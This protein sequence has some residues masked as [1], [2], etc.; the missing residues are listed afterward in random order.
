VGQEFFEGRTGR[1]SSDEERMT[2]DDGQMQ[3][4]EGESVE[5]ACE[6]RVSSPA[7][8]RARLRSQASS[9]EVAVSPLVEFS[10]TAFSAI[11]FTVDPFAAVPLFLTM[12]ANDT[13]GHRRRTALRAAV[14]VGVVLLLFAFAGGAIFRLFGISMGAF[15]MAGGLLL[16]LMALDMMRAH[17]SDTR[18]TDEEVAEGVDK[19]DVGIVPLGLPML[20]GPGAIATVTV[21]MNT[22]WNRPAHMTAVVACVLITTAIVYVVLRSAGPVARTLGATGLNV[23]NRVMGLILAAVAVQFVAGGL[24]ELF[25]LVLLA[26]TTSPA[27]G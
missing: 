2:I 10:L 26:P 21:L 17:R 8:S 15:R 3:N 19:S 5:L 25:P 24:R 12:T 7:F 22:A 18:T 14:T 6:L 16:F 4:A 1:V 27:G 11:F 23:L 9:I 20:A 13:P